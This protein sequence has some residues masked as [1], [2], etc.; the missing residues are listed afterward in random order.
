MFTSSCPPAR[1]P[2]RSRSA[3]FAGAASSRYSPS[4]QTGMGMSPAVAGAMG[5][6]SIVADVAGAGKRPRTKLRAKSW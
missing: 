4:A 2:S 1:L 5:V 6:S 3:S